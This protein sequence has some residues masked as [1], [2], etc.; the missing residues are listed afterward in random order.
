VVLGS[1]DSASSDVTA[2]DGSSITQEARHIITLVVS[3]VSQSG[4][5]DFE[6]YVGGRLVERIGFEVRSSSLEDRVDSLRLDK[7][8]ISQLKKI[9]LV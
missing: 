1:P 7:L 3:G 4:S 9:I 5:I 8:K 6:R 2:A